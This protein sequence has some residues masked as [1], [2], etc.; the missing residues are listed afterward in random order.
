ML[1]SPHGQLERLEAELENKIAEITN[2][3]HKL[4][5]ELRDRQQNSSIKRQMLTSAKQISSLVSSFKQAL[6]LFTIDLRRQCK[7]WTPPNLQQ[8]LIEQISQLRQRDR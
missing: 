2:I 8:E 5:A 1:V 6:Y 4:E 3:K 7:E